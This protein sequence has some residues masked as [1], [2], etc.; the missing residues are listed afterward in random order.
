MAFTDHCDLCAMV[1]EEGV[2]LIARHI[3]RQRPSLFNYATAYIAQHPELKLECKPVYHTRDVTDYGN[4]LFHV[5]GPLPL[6]G[7]DAP[8][9]ALN[10][11]AQLVEAKVDFHPGNLVTLPA[12]LNPPLPAQRFALFA[13]VCGGVDCP[14]AEILDQ[15]DPWPPGQQPRPPGPGGGVAGG[16]P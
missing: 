13:R 15:I 16:P 9:V 12:E 14:A 4:P 3:M 11:C 7:V 6:L 8:P 5:R 2:N 1:S 10:Y